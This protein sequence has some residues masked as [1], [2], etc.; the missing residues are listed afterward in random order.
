M[1]IGEKIQI[2]RPRW[3][4]RWLHG[5]KLGMVIHQRRNHLEIITNIRPR[6]DEPV[7][8]DDLSQKI[9]EFVGK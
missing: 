6:M 4:G 7:V 5:H 3:L 9:G 8:L 2:V 1:E